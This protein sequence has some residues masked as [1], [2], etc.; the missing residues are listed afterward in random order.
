MCKGW[1]P[2]LQSGRPLAC[3]VADTQTAASC[4]GVHWHGVADT[5]T[6]AVEVVDEQFQ[7][8]TVTMVTVVSSS[9]RFRKVAASV[10]GTGRPVR[11]L[12]VVRHHDGHKP[13]HAEFAKALTSWRI[14]LVYTPSDAPL[15]PQ[16]GYQK[17]KQATI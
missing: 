7:L 1:H 3:G 15:L 14:F 11:M 6:T 10:R 2:T 17:Q 13:R 5:W 4:S 8:V 16:R 9:H 12:Q